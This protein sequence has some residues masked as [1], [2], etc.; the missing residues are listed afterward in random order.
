MQIVS[1]DLTGAT[2]RALLTF[3]HQAMHAVSPPGTA[4]ALDLSGLQQPG[5][6]V[7]T[8][9]DGE[10]VLG[11]GALKVLPDGTG[12]VKSMRTDPDHLRKGV[13]RFMLEHII[14]EAKARG[15][16]RLS[17]ETGTGPDFEAALTLYRR[18]GFIEGEAFGD[19][20]AVADSGFN[21]FFH[22]DLA[23]A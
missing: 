11:I 10:A 14:A 20:T 23:T 19:Y 3:H 17:L 4:F 5:I 22:L 9:R 6:T 1:D 8:V 18:R 16:S 21:R 13:A 7:W 15:L 12:E 2:T